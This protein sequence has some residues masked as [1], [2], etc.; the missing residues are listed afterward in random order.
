MQCTPTCVVRNLSQ[1]MYCPKKG[2]DVVSQCDRACQHHTHAQV[3]IWIHTLTCA[4]A[5]HIQTHSY[6]HTDTHPHPH[7][8]PHLQPH[9]QTH[10]SLHITHTWRAIQQH[11]P[12]WL[13]ERRAVPAQCQHQGRTHLSRLSV[14]HT[15]GADAWLQHQSSQAHCC[16]SA[17][18]GGGPGKLSM[19]HATCR[20]SHAT[21]RLPWALVCRMS[22]TLHQAP[23]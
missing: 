1:S 2:K 12:G 19:F 23:F 6:V 22:N 11:T 15:H 13:P 7:P 4:R 18:Q 20:V 9:P 5:S 3:R 10:T 17:R 16:Q 21:K 8:H 14:T